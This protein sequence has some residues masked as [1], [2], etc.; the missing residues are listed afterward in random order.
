MLSFSVL[1]AVVQL[2]VRPCYFKYKSRRSLFDNPERILSAI[3]HGLLNIFR[4]FFGGE[5]LVRKFFT[6]TT[7][8]LVPLCSPAEYCEFESCCSVLIAI[9]TRKQHSVVSYL[10]LLYILSNTEVDNS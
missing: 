9:L 5:P 4:L 2:I 1:P 6:H 10:L 3:S 8:V 7:F